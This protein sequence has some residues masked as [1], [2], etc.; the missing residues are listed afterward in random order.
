MTQRVGI[1][2]GTFDPV[3][4]GHIASAK[5]LVANLSLDILYFMP[6]QQHAFH[7]HPGASPSQRSQMLSLAVADEENLQ[8]DDRELR[9][10]GISYTVDSLQAIRSEFGDDAIIVFILGTDA[11]ASLHQWDRWQSL[12]SFA[13]V[14]V[15]ERAGQIAAAQIVEPALKTLLAQSV[16]TINAPHGE[17]V[18]LALAPYVISSTELRS[19]LASIYQVNNQIDKAQTN[20]INEFIPAAVVQYINAHQLYQPNQ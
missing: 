8:V 7:K 1:F 12:L 20:M 6:C 18:Q 9:R 17:L 14:A 15:I 16:A 4:Y 19:A 11:F 13:N 5:M 3:H 2:G 10:D